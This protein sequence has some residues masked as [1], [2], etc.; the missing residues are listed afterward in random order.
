MI[1]E[2]SG[3]IERRKGHVKERSFYWVTIISVRANPT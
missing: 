1:K 3:R 2:E